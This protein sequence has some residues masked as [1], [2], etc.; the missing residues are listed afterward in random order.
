MNIN[1][2]KPN[3]NKWLLGASNDSSSSS[4]DEEFSDEEFSSSDDEELVSETKQEEFYRT[5]YNNNSDSD[6]DS[7]SSEEEEEEKPIPKVILKGEIVWDSEKGDKFY[8]DKLCGNEFFAYVHHLES[9]HDSTVII[10]IN[11]SDTTIYSKE[12]CTRLGCTSAKKRKNP[13][14]G[15]INDLDTIDNS[16]ILPKEESESESESDEEEE[17]EEVIENLDPMGNL[18]T[19]IIT[20][21]NKAP[22]I[23]IKREVGNFAV[24]IMWSQKGATKKDLFKK[25]HEIISVAHLVKMKRSGQ[26]INREK[27]KLHNKKIK[28]RD[29]LIQKEKAKRDQNWEEFNQLKQLCEIAF[30]RMDDKYVS[31]KNPK[32]RAG[33]RSRRQPKRVIVAKMKSLKDYGM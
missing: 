20:D 3:R 33:H 6:T 13:Y 22:T 7:D 19:Q 26:H 8:G 21:K 9:Q 15:H 12:V 17:E 16:N 32:K 28:Y 27:D 5:V 30:V 24:C 23:R 29:L 25:A 10:N 14:T 4:E 2:L 31:P 18:G 1:K 11:S